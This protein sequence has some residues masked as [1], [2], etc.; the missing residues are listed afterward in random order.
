MLEWIGKS[1]T[2]AICAIAEKTPCRRRKMRPI[3]SSGC[4]RKEVQV[5]KKFVAVVMVWLILAAM[6]AG[7]RTDDNQPDQTENPVQTEEALPETTQPAEVTEAATQSGLDK[8]TVSTKYGNLYY[9]DQW[10]DVMITELTEKD[11]CVVVDFVAEING[12]RYPLFCVI[13]GQSEGDPVG[14]ITDAQG[15]KHDVFVHMEEIGGIA[16]LTEGEQNRLF[17]MQEEINFVIESLE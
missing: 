2:M 14:Q 8:V 13:L 1:V 4:M 10:E 9:Q 7:C 6:L 3:A 17:A 16:D 15:G 5:L 12:V 11:T